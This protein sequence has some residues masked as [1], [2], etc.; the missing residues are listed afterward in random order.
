MK[1]GAND[2]ALIIKMINFIVTFAIALFQS[3]NPC[4]A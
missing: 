2:S 3:E 4:F 1:K